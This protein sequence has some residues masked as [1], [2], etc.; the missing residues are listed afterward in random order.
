[1]IKVI[2]FDF[3]GVVFDPK[4]SQP[5][6]G[7][8]DFLNKLKEQNVQCGM[9][10]SSSRRFIKPFLQEHNLQDYFG[11]VI[12]IDEVINTKPNIECYSKVAEFF[13]AEIQDCVVIDDSLPPVEQAKKSGFQ[14]VLFGV[15]A[16]AFTD[17]DLA[18]YTTDHV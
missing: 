8:V 16:Q 12:G 4:T 18:V 15:E 6:D 17:I 5:M 10:S 3:W 11:V 14:T 7:L 9:A 13:K 1:M 2:I